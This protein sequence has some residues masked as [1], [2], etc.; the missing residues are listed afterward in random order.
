VG[1]A[2]D[3]ADEAEI[4]THFSAGIVGETLI[5]PIFAGAAVSADGDSR[6]YLGIGRLFR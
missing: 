3:S 6:F 5:G 4:E 2:F 1:S